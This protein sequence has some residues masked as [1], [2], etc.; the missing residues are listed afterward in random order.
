MPQY[1]E[2]LSNHPYLFMALFVVLTLIIKTEIDNRFSGVIQSNA[3]EA[4]RLMDEDGMLIL[5]VRET[6]E[7]GA[8]HIRN[9]LHIPLSSLKSRMKEL[10]KYKNKTVLAYC[11]SGARSNTACR[12]LKK[13]GFE[14][15]HNLAGG[16]IAWGSANLPLTKK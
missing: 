13:A 12:Q 1:I 5:D 6:S 15:P 8:G 3:L 14:K 9:A 16:V 10:D 2:F 4:V 11:R 7:Y